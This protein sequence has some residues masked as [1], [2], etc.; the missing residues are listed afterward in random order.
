MTRIFWM[1]LVFAGMALGSAECRAQDILDKQLPAFSAKPWQEFMTLCRVAETSCGEE[2]PDDWQSYKITG[3]IKLDSGTVR[4]ALNAI[5]A[6]YPKSRWSVSSDGV[7]HLMPVEGAGGGVNGSSLTGFVMPEGKISGNLL[8]I[9]RFMKNGCRAV[10]DDWPYTDSK[11][12]ADYANVKRATCAVTVGVGET[13]GEVLSKAG[14]QVNHRFW[15]IKPVFGNDFHIQFLIL[16]KWDGG[17]KS[18]R[19][20][21]WQ[22]AVLEYNKE[23]QKKMSV[24][25]RKREEERARALL[26][27]QE[28]WARQ[29]AE[30]KKRAQRTEEDNR[31]MNAFDRETDGMWLSSTTAKGTDAIAAK[32]LG[33]SVTV[34]RYVLWMTM[35]YKPFDEQERLAK[36][37]LA[38]ASDPNAFDDITVLRM[39]GVLWSIEFQKGNYDKALEDYRAS[40]EKYGLGTSGGDLELARLTRITLLKK[41]EGPRTEAVLAMIKAYFAEE[42][43]GNKDELFKKYY[44]SDFPAGRYQALMAVF[45]EYRGKEFQSASFSF[46][47]ETYGEVRVLLTIAGPTGRRVPRELYFRL[48]KVDGQWKFTW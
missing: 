38:E 45:A 13:L 24:A 46:H 29:N 8:E 21:T 47:T 9:C 5:V 7:L 15:K 20:Q 16:K 44:T 39:L 10:G 26:K 32:Y 42:E 14:A 40:M 33:K 23:Q 18:E 30:G 19:K 43:A 48:M 3:E 37:I 11:N 6:R 36:K 1:F 41:T 17:G 4:S 2:L 25:D 12:P 34:D 22:E 28:E 27:M 31:L 35:T